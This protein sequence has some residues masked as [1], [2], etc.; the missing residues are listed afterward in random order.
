[1]LFGV[2]EVVEVSETSEVDLLLLNIDFAK[3][4]CLESSGQVVMDVLLLLLSLILES[5]DCDLLSFDTGD[6]VPEASNGCFIVV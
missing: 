3:R 5:C 1:M 4:D 6:G 2:L